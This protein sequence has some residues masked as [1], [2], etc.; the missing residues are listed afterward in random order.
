MTELTYMQDKAVAAAESVPAEKI[1]SVS[2]L[3]DGPVY[4]V[5]I[6]YHSIRLRKFIP[7][8]FDRGFFLFPRL[9]MPRVFR[10]PER[11]M[12]RTRVADAVRLPAPVAPDVDLAA[13]PVA[14]PVR[15]ILGIADHFSPVWLR[16]PMPFA[17]F[18]QSR[19]AAGAEI[20]GT[21]GKWQGGGLGEREPSAS[22]RL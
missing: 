1:E 12:S 15:M 17:A 9:D 4:K 16:A 2:Q 14:A 19:V 10:L 11:S 7:G 8:H 6:E 20:C 13:F 5:F 3:C 18:P 21:I 22:E